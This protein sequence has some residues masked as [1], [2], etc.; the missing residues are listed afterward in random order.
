MARPT[1]PAILLAP[2]SFKGTLSAGEVADALLAGFEHVG[3]RGDMCPLADGG[4][5]T[6]DVLLGALGG[7]RVAVEVHDALGR[8][9]EASYGVSADGQVAIVETAAAIGLGRL[10]ESEHDPE[11]ASSAGAGEL[12][13]AAAQRAPAVLVGL[14]GSAS[15]DGGAGALAAIEDAGGL[16]GVPLTCLCDVATPWEL[17]SETYGPQKGADSAA[18]ERLAARLD[19]LAQELPRDPRGVPMTGAA[20]GVAGGLWAALGAELVPGASYVAGAVGFDARAE[21]AGAVVTGEGRL[22]ETTLEGKVVAEVAARCRRL[23]VPLHAV[24]GADGSSE[25]VRSSLRLASVS[26][27]GDADAIHDAA[28]AIARRHHTPHH[29]ASN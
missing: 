6:L 22:D 18:V 12:I 14:G 3:V 13:A 19:A 1:G 5:G 24:V 9:T 2:G 23:G 10:S 15:N 7:E 4:D 28:V 8:P 21:R 11:A 16:G 17:A 27:A 25:G 29:R 20:G 26:E